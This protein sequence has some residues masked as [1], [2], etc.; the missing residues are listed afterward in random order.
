[1]AERDDDVDARAG[2]LEA[3]HL[4]K[5]NDP[6]VAEN[7]RGQ[8][9]SPGERCRPAALSSDNGPYQH[10]TKFRN[11]PLGEPID[12]LTLRERPPGA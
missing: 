2:G 8:I 7:R 5:A 11:A 9:F 3:L 10:Y 6:L 1:M 12:P 4:K